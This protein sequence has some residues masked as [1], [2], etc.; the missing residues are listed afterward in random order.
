[1]T[2]NRRTAK[3]EAKKEVATTQ[4]G[5][6]PALA[7]K[8]AEHAGKGVSGAAED[9]LIPLIYILQALSPQ[10]NKKN[11]AYIDGAE[12]S[13]IW[14]R[15]APTPIIDGEVG[16]LF[17]PCHFTKGYVEWVPRD[18]GGGFVARHA[19]LPVEAKA[20][21]DSKNPNKVT[22][23]MPNGNEV[24]ET[25]Y[26]AGH[27]LTDAGPLPYIIPMTGSGHTVSKSWMSVMNSHTLPDGNVMPS[28][29]RAYRLRTKER[30][31]TVGQSWFSWDISDEGFVS[32][33]DFDRGTRLNKACESGEK[34]AAAEEV[35]EPNSD[36]M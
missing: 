34:R 14:L 21:K 16:V 25:R 36:T 6:P 15:N 8:M 29:S 4:Q 10:V 19:A 11:P 9:N 30:T 32:E 31:N 28:W 13:S 5:L 18:S 27:V 1:M 2:K 12:P 35:V 26:H 23:K 17:Q 20:T 33:E 22:Y 24:V 3:A 7:S